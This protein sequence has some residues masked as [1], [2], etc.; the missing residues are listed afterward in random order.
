MT[1]TK[2]VTVAGVSAPG[3]LGKRW[4]WWSYSIWRIGCLVPST[5]TLSRVLAFNPSWAKLCASQWVGAIVSIDGNNDR[6]NRSV[7]WPPT[8]TALS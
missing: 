6:A 4:R 2:K 5:G 7:P 3:H 8:L 1:I